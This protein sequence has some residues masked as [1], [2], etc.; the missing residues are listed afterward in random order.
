[1]VK[2]FLTREA[3]L[4]AQDLPQEEVY[5]PE[6][7][8]YVRVRGLTAAERDALESTM[9]QTNGQVRLENFRARLVAMSIVD[10]E[11]NRLFS[12]EDVDA[13]GRKSAAALQRVFDVAMRLSGL[14][15]EDVE[16]LAK[17]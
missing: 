11:G 15:A 4:K 1:M 16:E 7:G 6:W 2:K 12:D 5:V 3:I 14:R 13:L 17:N 8:G 10:E 9:L